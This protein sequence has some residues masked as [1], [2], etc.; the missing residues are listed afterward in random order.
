MR[1]SLIVALVMAA[2][3]LTGCAYWTTFNQ[4]IDLENRSVAIDAKQRV[5]YAHK[6]TTEETING[7]SVE[8][9]QVVI[10]AEPS[11]DALSVLGASGALTGSN[12]TGAG[13]SASGGVAESAASIGLR[14]QSIQLLR[15]LNYRICEAYSNG[16][17]DYTN[18]AALLRRS[19][20]TMM[21]LIAIEQL[22]GPVV[23][24][25]AALYASV[26]AGTGGSSSDV[27]VAQTAVATAKEN[28][29]KAQ[30][31]VDS[32]VTEHQKN[33]KAVEDTNKKLSDAAKADKPDQAAID[34]LTTS[35]QTAQDTAKTSENVLNDKQRR[36]K[37]A[38]ADLA[39]A[40]SKLLAAERGKTTTGVA[41]SGQ[42]GEVAR[43]NAVTTAALAKQVRGIVQDINQSYFRDAC[44]SFLTSA[45]SPSVVKLMATQQGLEQAAALDA[46]L[47]VC[48]GVFK[49]DAEAQAKTLSNNIK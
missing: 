37:S 38:E 11:P 47:K 4:P 29:L 16:A 7:K 49:A 24:G 9:S 30:A 23:A 8:K 12:T 33:L 10:C 45:T 46:A 41:T 5:I 31:E 27:T 43:A 44:F 22:T 32:A 28:L 34:A 18:A 21:G 42:L 20:S 39:D 13:G 35:L 1:V 14:T 15:D 25:Q 26:N 48:T 19:Q 6:N 40:K 2:V 36:A 3:E 17:I